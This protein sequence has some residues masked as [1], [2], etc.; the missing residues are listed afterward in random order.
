MNSNLELRQRN[1][2]HFSRKFF[3]VVGVVFMAV[4]YHNMVRETALT[5]LILASLGAVVL[6]IT[7]VR[8]AA[9]NRFVISIFG[10]LMREHE[11]TNWTG[12]TYLILGVLII[13]VLFPHDIVTLSLLFLAIADPAASYFGI[14]YGKDRL[15]GQ[16]S[17]QGSIAAFFACGLTSMVYYTVHHLML[18]RLLIVGIL[19]GLAGAIAEAAP[20]GQL[21]DNLVLPVLSAL[22]LWLIFYVF[23]GF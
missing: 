3:H 18:D 11:K 7:R 1:D 5:V 12:F 22:Q 8:I 2:I 19:S 16:K 23:G 9:L 14:R 6:E 13:V 21:D 15:W 10:P 20:L 4:L 17:L